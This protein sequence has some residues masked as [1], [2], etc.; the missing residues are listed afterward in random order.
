MR[1]VTQKI[2]GLSVA[3]SAVAVSGQAR[4][5]LH[6]SADASIG[7]LSKQQQGA[8]FAT[9]SVRLTLSG[10]LSSASATSRGMGTAFVTASASQDRFGSGIGSNDS[11]AAA[12]WQDVVTVHALTGAILPDHLDFH[13]KA[14]G[15]VALGGALGSAVI[16]VD[17]NGF[18]AQMVFAGG[19][20]LDG[21]KGSSWD[22]LT[23]MSDRTGGFFRGTY[24]TPV[25]L[26]VNAQG[27]GVGAWG[28]AYSVDAKA[29]PGG[30]TVING[31][32]PP[33]FSFL[34]VTLPDGNTPES[35]GFTLSFQSGIPSPN[36]PSVPEP[37][38]FVLACIGA[39]AL[40]GYGWR[41]RN[42]R[43]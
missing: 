24:H 17:A 18:S 21:P 22:T 15:R 30:E 35:E 38:S 37:S 31:G 27:D 23:F 5:D 7:G 8:T 32:D 42:Q 34:S 1:G 29:N 26:G 11:T 33:T 16:G 40:L 20:S 13:Y 39:I 9:A 3:L 41:R 10:E 36:L 12:S 28:L 4:A 43:A 19:S 6:A 14:S 2:L 25:L